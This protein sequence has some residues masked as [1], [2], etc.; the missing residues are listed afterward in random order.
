MKRLVAV[1]LWIFVNFFESH[2]LTPLVT[3]ARE[4]DVAKIRSL[5]RQGVDP[6]DGAGVNEW[7]PLMHAIHKDQIGAVA[8]LLDAHANPNLASSSGMTPLM[9]AAGYGQRK[10]VKL[11]LAR[12]AN[13][14]L[15][16][17]NGDTALDYARHG[18]ND[19]DHFTL[20]QRQEDVV[21][22]LLP[23]SGH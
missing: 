14:R 13:P 15:K 8:A 7:T 23:V 11:L 3:A 12:G 4:G 22:V 18:M 21:K 20:F 5:A 1:F 10:I 9:M 6:N 2:P 17:H 16:D 19:I